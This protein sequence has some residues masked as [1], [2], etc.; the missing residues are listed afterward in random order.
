MITTSQK[1]VDSD[2]KL[3]TAAGCDL[4]QPKYDGWWTRLELFAGICLVYS[5]TERLLDTWPCDPSLSMTLI[6]EYM[7]GTQWAQDPT[8]KGLVYLFDC[9][10][11]DGASLSGCE[12]RAR[13]SVLTA[14]QK[15][16]PK[17]FRHVDNFR[18]DTYENI[19]QACVENGDFEGV[20]FRKSKDLIDCTIYRQKLIVTIDLEVV[21]F[22]PGKPDGKYANLLGSVIGRTK[23]GVTV[24]VGG[25]WS[26]QQRIQIIDNQEVYLGLWFECEGRRQFASG[27]IRHPNFL[28]WREDKDNGK[29]NQ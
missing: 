4:L 14:Y 27:S 20:I 6:G 25:G 21:G 9:W 16:F 18:I 26:D 15:Y 17:N 19:W 1:Y 8:R 2:Y 23:D 5:A 24:D 13:Y 29:L 11:L 22:K 10:A 7:Y 3:A 12:Y 28:R